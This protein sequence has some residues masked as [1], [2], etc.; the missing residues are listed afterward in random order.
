MH[1]FSLF[2]KR[3]KMR[4]AA[5]SL[6]LEESF[7]EHYHKHICILKARAN[8]LHSERHKTWPGQAVAFWDVLAIKNK[9]KTQI[10]KQ[11]QE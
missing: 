8:D 7:T 9:Q 11:T 3:C 4:A 2:P 1:D 5:M 6:A 10:Q